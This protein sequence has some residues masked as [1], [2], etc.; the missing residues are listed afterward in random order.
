[1]IFT[2]TWYERLLGRRSSSRTASALWP[3]G[4]VFEWDRPGGGVVPDDVHAAIT[5]AVKEVER[6]VATLA[7]SYRTEPSPPRQ[8]SPPRLR[9]VR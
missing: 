8:P 3:S 7:D 1:L 2:P 6:E 9:I 5:K 4:T